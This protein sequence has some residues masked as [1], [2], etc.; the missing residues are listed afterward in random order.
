VR[1]QGRRGE[2]SVGS[3]LPST[4]R[5]AARLVIDSGRT[6]S[7]VAAELGLGAQLL[8]RWVS[9]ERESMEPEALS[10]DERAE[11]KRLRKE[12]ADLRMDN[13]FLEKAAAFFAG[14]HQ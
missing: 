10:V 6:I 14:K 4:A 5:E 13:E 7:A 8:G 2:L 12:N 11:L 9:A 1:E 3:S